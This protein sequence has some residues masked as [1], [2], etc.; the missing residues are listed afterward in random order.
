MAVADLRSKSVDA[1]GA[2]PGGHR[3][4]CKWT[5]Q[6]AWCT[7]CHGRPLPQGFRWAARTRPADELPGRGPPEWGR[8]EGPAGRL[9]APGAH[10]GEELSPFAK[11]G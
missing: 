6:V 10:T 1:P 4:A 8:L 5:G 2:G 11:G 3:G 9:P 7:S